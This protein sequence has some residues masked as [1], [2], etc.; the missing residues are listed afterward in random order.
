MPLHRK[1]Q[2]ELMS[3]FLDGEV[4]PT[5]A[6]EAEKLLAQEEAREMRAVRGVGDLL[7]ADV[8]RA[9][10][11][12]NFS[13]FADRVLANAEAQ[14][15]L[16]VWE[17]VEEFFREKFGVSTH[18]LLPGAVVAAAALA[19]FLVAQPRSTGDSDFTSGPRNELVITKADNLLGLDIIDDEGTTILWVDESE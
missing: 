2:L 13:F 1:D 19:A 16:S 6:L 5:E 10:A 4:T 7:R 3:R 8:E 18:Y 9:T 11:R 12:V 15:P 17:R 14:K